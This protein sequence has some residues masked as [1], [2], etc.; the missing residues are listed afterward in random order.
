[1]DKPATS[2]PQTIFRRAGT[3]KLSASASSRADAAPDKIVQFPTP[4]GA[5]PTGGTGRLPA[6]LITRRGLAPEELFHLA[7]RSLHVGSGWGC[8]PRMMAGSVRSGYS[9]GIFKRTQCSLKAKGLLER[10]QGKRKGGGRGRGYAVDKVTFETPETR[11]VVVD[12]ELFDGSLTPKEIACFLHVKVRGKNV[13]APWQLDER[14]QSTRPTV[15]GILKVLSDKELV[16]NY[17]SADAPQWGVAALK[18]PTFKKT[19]FKKSTFKKTTRTRVI[20]SPRGI[21]PSHSFTACTRSPGGNADPI[22]IRG[23]DDLA[24]AVGEA[25]RAAA[26]AEIAQ[27]SA[28]MAR[29]ERFPF[30]PAVLQEIAGLGLDVAI[31][32]EAYHTKTAGRHIRN[33]SAYLLR[34]GRDEAAKLLGVTPD[35]LK[36][37][38]TRDR[39]QRAV[40]LAAGVGIS[41]EPGAIV[42]RS[43]TRHAKL[44]GDDPEAMLR[45]WR[46]SVAGRRFG[47]P[48]EAERSLTAFACARVFN[49]LQAVQQ[50]SA[51]A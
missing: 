3:G 12:R 30:T 47:S 29:G 17:G 11:Y 4:K 6:S 38:A 24:Q 5:R 18:N 19:T 16:K 41:A 26:Q 9:E 46:A 44:R 31:V 10:Q 25:Q 2:R 1:M 33:P 40:E 35:T 21:S 34:M 23:T 37:I 48:A 8:N 43:V 28:E 51:P 32:L 42:L 14:L 50:C 27:C 49:R 39:K 20:R 22:P 15:N 36:K 45:D 13:L 7:Y